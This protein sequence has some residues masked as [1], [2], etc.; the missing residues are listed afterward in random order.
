MAGSFSD[1]METKVLQWAFVVGTPTRPS[2]TWLALYTVAPTDSSAGTEV[3]NANAYARTAVTMAVS[4]D[5]ATNSGVVS[6][7]AATGAYPAA[8]VAVAVVDSAT[9]GGGNIIAY[10]TLDN[11]KTVGIGDVVEFADGALDFTL[12]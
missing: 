2:G 4:G 7:P 9:Y 5:L 11:N 12:T 10:T 6:F 3:T 8:V 1:Q